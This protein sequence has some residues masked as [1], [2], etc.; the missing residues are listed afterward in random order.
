MAVRNYKTTRRN[1]S[2]EDILQ[3]MC[4]RFL[5]N[6]TDLFWHHPSPN[7]YRAYLALYAPAAT[8]QI[9]GGVAKRRGVKAGVWDIMIHDTPPAFPDKKGVYIELKVGTQPLSPEQKEFKIEAEKRGYLCFVVRD[10]TDNLRDLLAECG[11]P[12]KVVF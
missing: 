6:W 9:A 7:S 11:Y 5:D 1:H 2:K 8:C 3:E 12:M 4:A 10:T